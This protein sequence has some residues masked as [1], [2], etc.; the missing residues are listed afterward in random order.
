MRA[1]SRRRVTR[2]EVLNKSDEG[3]EVAASRD[4]AR[5]GR[6]SRRRNAFGATQS[7]A[8][9]PILLDARRAQP[10]K[11]LAIDH[12]LPSEEFLAPPVLRCAN[13]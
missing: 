3:V 9:L 6:S 5:R 2:P 12:T 1:P 7:A 8:L 13:V 10:G 4:A 11:N